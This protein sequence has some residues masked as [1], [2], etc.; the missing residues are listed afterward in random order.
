MSQ[1]DIYII[2]EH[3]L[4]TTQ[5]FMK[6]ELYDIGQA[7]IKH[8]QQFYSSSSETYPRGFKPGGSILGLAPHIASRQEDNGTDKNG[9]WTWAQLMVKKGKVILIITY[10]RVSQ[11]YPSEAGYLTVYMQQYRAFVKEIY[12][13]PSQNR[14]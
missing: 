1:A 9:R 8:D 2:N 14:E 6:K 7:E 4:D 5:V 13:T 12:S 10:Y 11:T 3:D